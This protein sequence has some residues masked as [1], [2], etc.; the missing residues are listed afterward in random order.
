MQ[1]CQ[2]LVVKTRMPEFQNNA[3]HHLLICCA[4]QNYVALPWNHLKYPIQLAVGIHQ[5]EATGSGEGAERPDSLYGVNL[6][7]K[8][9]H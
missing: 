3:K 5:V 6:Q 4:F 8:H 9:L 2:L 7:L 1:A